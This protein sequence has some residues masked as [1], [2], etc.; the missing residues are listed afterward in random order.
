MGRIKGWTKTKDL[1]FLFEYEHEAG[2]VRLTGYKI[3]TGWKVRMKQ[4][5][6]NG[7]Y[8]SHE[9]ARIHKTKSD[10]KSIAREQMGGY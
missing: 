7:W 6:V 2:T 4:F 5:G 10:A 3:P 9:S 1:P 8:V